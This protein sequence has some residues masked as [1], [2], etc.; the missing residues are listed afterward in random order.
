MPVTGYKN[1]GAMRKRKG[2]I[3]KVMTLTI[4][5]K[6]LWRSDLQFNAVFDSNDIH[7]IG[8]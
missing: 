1:F 3:T 2:S 6:T 7:K 5:L 4:L 8:V